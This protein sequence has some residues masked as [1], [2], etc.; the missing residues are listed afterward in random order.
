MGD[1]S[2]RLNN[3]AGHSS[4]NDQR[5]I[6]REFGITPS[7]LDDRLADSLMN[8]VG[9]SVAL[10]SREP[11]FRKTHNSF[12]GEQSDGIRHTL[13]TPSRAIYIVRDPRAVAVSM[14]H[15]M[16]YSQSQA[17]DVMET[18]PVDAQKELPVQGASA[19]AFEDRYRLRGC[20]VAFDW[21]S[22]STNVT[23]WID[24]TEIPVSTIRYEDLLADTLGTVSD[25]VE[26]LEFEI[27]RERI[28]QAVDESSFDKLAVQEMFGGFVEAT[29][30]DRQFFRRGQAD[31]WHEELEPGLE[32]RI[33]ADHEPTMRRLGYVP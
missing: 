31:S 33:I 29:S 12:C 27:P 1:G 13:R 19:E 17:V 30:P 4:G 8:E 28:E 14:A 10:H 23:S 26:W 18:G 9:A 22:W 20:Q 6:F 24:Q 25:L 32:E 7:V 2:V 3:L 11:V 21:G 15:H 16:G 5:A